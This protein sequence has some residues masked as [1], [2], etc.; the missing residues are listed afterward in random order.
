MRLHG[1]GFFRNKR[2]KSRKGHI[3]IVSQIPDPMLQS[4]K[5]VNFRVQ[6]VSLKENGGKMNAAAIFG[7]TL[8]L[9][10]LAGWIFDHVSSND[11]PQKY[12]I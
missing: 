5:T 6:T 11:S 4:R 8:I 2:K 12:N 3:I 10:P 1:T 7:A 9:L